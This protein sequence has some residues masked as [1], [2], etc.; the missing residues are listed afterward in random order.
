VPVIERLAQNLFICPSAV[1]QYAALACFEPES[2][3]E[4]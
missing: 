3:A 1:A 2:I 4:Y